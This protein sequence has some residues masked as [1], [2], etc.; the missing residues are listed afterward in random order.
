[1]T[2]HRNGIEG[3]EIQERAA[4]IL[5]RDT[6]LRRT[7]RKL[8]LCYATVRTFE[9]RGLLPSADGNPLAAGLSNPGQHSRRPT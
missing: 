6:S 9:F 2:L 1:M 4:R 3:P 8:H 5:A 7:A